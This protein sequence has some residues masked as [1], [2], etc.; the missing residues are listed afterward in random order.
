MSFYYREPSSRRKL[1]LFLVNVL[2]FF[3][4]LT[5]VAFGPTYDISA[6]MSSAL[7]RSAIYMPIA[8]LLG[9]LLATW[10]HITPR[11]ART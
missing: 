4:A 3:G 7:L 5:A 8:S 10:V 9:L 6:H 11:E 1:I 2:V